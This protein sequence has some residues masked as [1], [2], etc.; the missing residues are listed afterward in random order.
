[1]NEAFTLYTLKMMTELSYKKTI[2]RQ[3][4][5]QGHTVVYWIKFIRAGANWTFGRAQLHE[6]SNENPE[7]FLPGLWMHLYSNTMC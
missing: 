4:W 6:K 1:M 5:V 3:F 2:N 7:N